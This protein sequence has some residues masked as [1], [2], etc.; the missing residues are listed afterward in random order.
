MRLLAGVAVGLLVACGDRHT[1]GAARDAGAPA[2]SLIATCAEV[3]GTAQVRR[4]GRPYWEPLSEGGTLRDGDWVRT[5]AE[6]HARL[7]LLAGGSID[8]NENAVVV[9]EM[10]K[11]ED[12]PAGV[13]ATP[14][15]S[16]ES[17][18]VQATPAAADDDTVKPLLVR[19]PDGKTSVLQGTKGEQH[20]MFRLSA[21]DAGMSVAAVR[22]QGTLR[23]GNAALPVSP[24]AAAMLTSEAPPQAV[25][26][27][28]FPASITPGIDA[29]LKLEE[30]KT[31]TKLL[32][33]PVDE[34]V[35]Y[36]VQ[37]ARDLSFTVQVKTVDVPQL[38]YTL[39]PE[40]KGLYVWRVATRAAGGVIGEYGFARRI[41][42][43]VEQ[44]KE[45]LL[46]PEDATTVSYAGDLPTLAFTWQALAEHTTYRLLL[47][48]G[49]DPQGDPLISL[50]TE[51]QRAEVKTL[52]AGEYH[53]GVYVDGRVLKPLFLKPRKILVK[54]VPR[55]VVKTPKSINKWE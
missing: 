11:M 33:S 13:A 54:A 35:G 29:R 47:S 39:E 19:T 44:P 28:D 20:T 25:E 27:P 50:T 1:A 55:A 18:E 24:K 37:T 10:P 36:R 41:F 26:L 17:G 42:Y 14:R 45:M 51:Q 49:G 38:G 53:W 9:V 4:A 40:G 12:V 52:G 3:K 5:L 30:G 48:R 43:E 22:G 23:S 7:E 46:G 32:W 16:V 21:S 31:R 2:I 15:V 6:S 34:A 8:L